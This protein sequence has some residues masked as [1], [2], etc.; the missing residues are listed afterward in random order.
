MSFVFPHPAKFPLVSL[1]FLLTAVALCGCAQ[2]TPRV[3]PQPSESGE[4]N[5]INLAD[6][7]QVIPLAPGLWRHVSYKDLPDFGH[8]PANGLVLCSGG[9]ALLIDTPWTD[10]QTARLC[11]W[12]AREQGARV[13]AA[14]PTHSHE[15]CIGGLRE[16]HRRGARSYALD[17]C[18]FLARD[19]GKEAP[20]TAFSDAYK[21]TV[22]GQTV[23]LRYLG[24][25]HTIDNIV[26]WI[27]QQQVLFGG[28]LIK[29]A[30]ARSLGYT[31]E[32]ELS[33]WPATLRAV[34]TRYPDARLIVPGHGDPGGFE[35]LTR[36]LELLR[37]RGYE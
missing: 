4:S 20:Q 1:T 26:V 3:A 9:E 5:V 29:S 36:T 23:E 32:A 17:K 2:R 35:L 18:V 10:D 34:R 21:L 11:D 16:V 27:P 7:L 22:G 15:D 33:A 31:R 8:T 24:G 30:D 12:L 19:T 6:D 13:T 14:I 28:C 37:E 25:G